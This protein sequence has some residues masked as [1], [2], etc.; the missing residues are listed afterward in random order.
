MKRLAD[1]VIQDRLG[2]PDLEWAWLDDR[3]LDPAEQA[4]LLDLYVRSGVYT[5]NEARASA[6]KPPARYKPVLAA[7]CAATP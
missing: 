3:A 7:K 6:G 2:H 1:H 5:I 4:K